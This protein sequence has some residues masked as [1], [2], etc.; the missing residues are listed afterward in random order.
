MDSN[1]DDLAPVL[2]RLTDENRQ[3]GQRAD[4]I[5]KAAEADEK[6]LARERDA[7]E[8]ACADMIRCER[9]A[10]SAAYQK[11]AATQLLIRLHG[12]IASLD[13]E[14]ERL[15]AALRGD[16][17]AYGM[18]ALRV[19]QIDDV[20]S[21]L[22]AR[23]D[24]WQRHDKECS[25][26]QRA[27]M[28]LESQTSHQSVE[29]QKA[30]TDLGKQRER[31]DLLFGEMDALRA[32]RQALFGERDPDR[33]ETAITETVEGADKQ[34][35]AARNEH[36]AATQAVEQ[37]RARVQQIEQGV[38]QRDEQ[39]QR[40]Q[41]DFTARLPAAG[42]VD[43]DAYVAAS[44]E[45]V[46]RKAL[47]DRARQLENDR[48]A[49]ET[50]REN[51]E[52]QLETERAKALT[53]A[54]QDELTARLASLQ[55]D[56]RQLQQV[57]G[58]ISQRLD[59]NE[60][61]KQAQQE[62]LAA[63]E[64]Q[65]REA[66]RWDRLHELIGSADGKKYRN[67]AQGLTFEMMVGH[68]N[69]QLQ[70]LTDRYLL[71]RDDRQPLDLNVVDNYQAGEI[72]STRNLSGGETFLVSLSLALG[73]SQMASRNVRV[74]SLFLDEGFG[75]L[76]EDALETALETLSGLQEDGKLIGV[77]SHVAAL[78]ERIGTQIQVVPQAGGRSVV[79]GPGCRKVAEE[80]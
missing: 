36:V 3:A 80:H 25:E 62:R 4:R 69:R 40:L 48:I 23:R 61:L 47:E 6:A 34:S 42:F 65:R 43:E 74:D 21:Q 70:K 10:Q 8:H 38:R 14:Q 49:L 33:E 5:I 55:S 37:I 13:E 63:I 16:L 75:T 18:Y 20:R 12:E 60:C 1:V 27:A 30:E 78:K 17:E 73:L 15:L 28:T 29:I 31:R 41:S 79:A 68:A 19:E 9:E 56:H 72:R 45:P 22:T 59:D 44:L 53:D 71:I 66:A 26:Q 7:L 58:S 67:F 24:A 11:E 77:I 50:T 46:E 39:L 51:A 32:E 35:A 76:D 57:V 52:K 64:L 54:A 2:E